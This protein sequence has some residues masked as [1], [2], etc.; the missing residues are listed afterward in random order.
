MISLFECTSINLP[1]VTRGPHSLQLPPKRA[2]G[3]CTA[4]C[5]PPVLLHRLS[6]L[7]QRRQ[8]ASSRN[9][10]PYR[11]HLAKRKY[12]TFTLAIF[13]ADS[14]PLG[15]QLDNKGY[16]CPQCGKSFSPLE[17]DKLVDFMAGTFNCDICRAEL[18]DNENAESVKGSQD[19]MQRFNRQMRFI[20]E[21]LR[22]SEDMV[23]PA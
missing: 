8:M 23:L 19:R 7:L 1:T 4:F 17:V 18:T 22:R 2:E 5:R 13:F 9:A 15:Q 11:F 14:P 12:L 3:G 20:R 10:P 6:V 21:G 16:I